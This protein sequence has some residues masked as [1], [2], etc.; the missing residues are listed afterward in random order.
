MNLY[1]VTKGNYRV[2]RTILYPEFPE[3][4]IVTDAQVKAV[5]GSEWDTKITINGTYNGPADVVAVKDYQL[6]W[7]SDGK[8]IIESGSAT[9]ELKSGGTLRQVW[10]STITPDRGLEKFPQT[11]EQINI[12]I[13]PF[14][15]DEKGMSYKWEGTVKARSK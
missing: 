15:I 11:G 5:S 1:D 13:S 2:Q 14:Q 6:A 9:L 3:S 10:T 8:N 4:K 7:T 12:T